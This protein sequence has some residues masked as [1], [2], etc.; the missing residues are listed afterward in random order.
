MHRQMPWKSIHDMRLLIIN[1]KTSSN[2]ISMH[3]QMPST[4]IH[5]IS[6]SVVNDKTNL[7]Y[8]A[9]SNLYLIETNNSKCNWCGD[10]D[11]YLTTGEDFCNNCAGT[12]N[13]T[14]PTL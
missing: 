8:V 1:N 14:N 9:F 6:L 13:D 5:N 10:K 4:L 2:F 12:N 7:K 11:K 3:R